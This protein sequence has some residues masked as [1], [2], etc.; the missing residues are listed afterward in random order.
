MADRCLARVSDLA[1]LSHVAEGPCSVG[2]GESIER[3]SRSIDSSGGDRHIP[4]RDMTVISVG[5]RGH[6]RRF[7]LAVM[8]DR[9]RWW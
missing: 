3:E 6:Q 2:C 1:E 5:V 7:C 4:L 8:I 9:W